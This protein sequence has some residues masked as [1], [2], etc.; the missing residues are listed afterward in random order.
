LKLLSIDFS[1]Y[2]RY[3]EKMEGIKNIP[4]T[5]EKATSS[6]EISPLERAGEGV[7]I[8]KDHL[9][10]IS[11]M[12]KNLADV[13]EGVCHTNPYNGKAVILKD[14][15]SFAELV[16]MLRTASHLIDTKIASR[17]LYIS[18]GT[19]PTASDLQRM[20]EDLTRIRNASHPTYELLQKA[21]L[22]FFSFNAENADKE[23]KE[24][25]IIFDQDALATASSATRAV[26][27]HALRLDMDVMI[28]VEKMKKQTKI[29]PLS[30]PSEESLAK[31]G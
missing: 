12:A 22:S 19:E 9:E 5:G 23:Y 4:E 21:T 13:I 28:D 11:L 1:V 8:L 30:P 3:M 20:H 16:P 27:E 17:S 18:Q 14:G 10:K 29:I 2:N 15:S 25:D 24:A 31:T 26:T 7:E 6:R